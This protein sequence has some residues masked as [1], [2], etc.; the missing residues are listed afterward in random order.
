MQANNILSVVDKIVLVTGSNRGNGLA[1]S[2]GLLAHGAKVLRIDTQFDH[3]IGADDYVFDLNNIDEIE[4]LLMRLVKRYKHV[5]GLV[6]NAGI[7]LGSEKPYDDFSLFLNTMNVNLNSAFVLTAG[8]LPIMKERGGSIINVTSLGAELAFPDNPSYQVSKAGLRQLTKAI[9]KDWAKYNIRANNLCPGYI[10]TNMTNKSFNDEKMYL[11]RLNR[12][13]I[14]RWGKSE[15]LI[16][17]AL[18]LL[19]DASAYITASDIYVDG[20]W[21]S[22]GL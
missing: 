6:N 19:S 7:S 13:I 17:P 14:K 1:I 5:D 11:E 10:K 18:F 22:N 2:K 15:D 21:T 4:I 16:G 8:I 3:D 9:A 20:G 12:M